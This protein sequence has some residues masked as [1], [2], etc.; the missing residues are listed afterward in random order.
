MDGSFFE[1]LALDSSAPGVLRLSW[2]S[3]Q[4][5]S[6]QSQYTLQSHATDTTLAVR[7]IFNIRFLLVVYRQHSLL[8]SR[9]KQLKSVHNSR[10]RLHSKEL[11]RQTPDSVILVFSVVHFDD[12]T[13]FRSEEK[14]KEWYA[15]QFFSLVAFQSSSLDH[16]QDHNNHYMFEK[17]KGMSNLMVSCSSSPLRPEH[18]S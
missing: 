7:D 1:V 12:L 8:H 4:S 18:S 6:Q 3:L 5:D 17:E 13:C 15:D 2:P 11:R 14:L 16:I 9:A 10:A